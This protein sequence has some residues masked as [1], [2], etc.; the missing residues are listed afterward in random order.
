MEDPM[1][2][3]ETAQQIYAA[4]DIDEDFEMN[5]F[6]PHSFLEGDG[7]VAAMIRRGL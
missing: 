7:L 2:N 4:F 6:D 3:V 5:S 1:S